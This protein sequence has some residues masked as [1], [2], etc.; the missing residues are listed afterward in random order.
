M[1]TAEPF[2]TAIWTV[3]WV[4]IRLAGMVAVN[5]LELTKVVV[6]TVGEL[7][8]A[9]HQVTTETPFTKLEPLTVNV[10]AL[11]IPTV[12][13]VGEMELSPG[14]LIVNV[15]RLEE[16]LSVASWMEMDTV[17]TVAIK[18]AL[19]VAVIE[20][21]PEPTV[22]LLEGIVTGVPPEGVQIRTSP[23]AKS[24]PVII[25]ENVGLPTGMLAGFRPLVLMVGPDAMV[26]FRLLEVTWL[27]ESVTLTAAVPAVV[28]KL[29]GTLT[30]IEDAE[31]VA[32]VRDVTCPPNVQFTTG[33]D[34]GKLLPVNVR[35][36]L[37]D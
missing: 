23:A 29:A 28:S 14:L 11:E 2:S 1:E 27:T 13:P 37:V 16:T 18:E 12:V 36:K 35:L 24:A 3:P 5:W 33:E 34:A 32:T 4:V 20:V 17:P 25:R 31:L 26:K 10:V 19:I 8:H 30:V 15:S 7:P 6:N 9:L 22:R 21:P